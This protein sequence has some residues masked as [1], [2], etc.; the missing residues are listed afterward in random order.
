MIL[1]Y[2]F[3]F[4]TTDWL[5]TVESSLAHFQK[6]PLF[7]FTN[8]KIDATTRHWLISK[9]TRQ[10]S[11]QQF[12]HLLLNFLP[13]LVSPLLDKFINVFRWSFEKC[14]FHFVNNF[15]FYLYFHLASLSPHPE[16]YKHKDCS[17]RMKISE[18][19]LLMASLSIIMN[20]PFIFV[21]T[22]CHQFL[23]RISP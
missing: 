15:Q 8:W 20:L 10:T 1:H 13:I 5:S 21:L 9:L 3:K 7:N 22:T 19:R 18:E 23:I 6:W 14:N 11:V 2:D 17:R 12:E 4:P 16:L